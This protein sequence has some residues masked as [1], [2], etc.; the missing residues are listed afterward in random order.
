[1]VNARS[2]HAQEIA[3]S[4]NKPSLDAFQ[5]SPI[6]EE[7]TISELMEQL[8]LK[9]QELLNNEIAR[10][11]QKVALDTAQEL[12]ESLKVAHQLAKERGDRIYVELRVSRRNVQ[13]NTASIAKL[14]EQLKSFSAAAKDS[15]IAIELLEKS[16]ESLAENEE[17]MSDLIES[18][19]TEVEMW[20]NKLAASR[21]E[22]RNLRARVDRAPGIMERAIQKA[23]DQVK[24]DEY[25][26]DLMEKG[27]YTPEARAL[28]R[29]LVTAGC[30][31]DY[32]GILIQQISKSVGVTVARKMSRRTVSRSIAEG[33]VAAQIQMGM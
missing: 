6:T 15:A 3:T 28:A 11:A 27:I 25:V 13:R 12:A 7:P 5:P 26:F 10:E 29:C 33:G 17:R 22:E 21:Q 20:K 8:D 2:S 14:K 23:V 18:C 24:K 1:M 16:E 31:Q 32:V 9:D 30:S 19:K 4:A